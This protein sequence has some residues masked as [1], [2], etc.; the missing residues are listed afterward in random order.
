MIMWTFKEKQFKIFYLNVH[1]YVF[2]QQKVQ[3]EK[4]NTIS[5]IL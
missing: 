5:L 4:D 1:T 2:L 3:S